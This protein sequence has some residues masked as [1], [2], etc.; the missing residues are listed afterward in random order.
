MNTRTF[1]GKN[2]HIPESS[3][4]SHWL[5]GAM[6]TIALLCLALGGEPALAGPIGPPNPDPIAPGIDIGSSG[7]FSVR[8]DLRKCPSPLCGGVFVQRV[9]HR[10]TRCND[11]TLRPECYVAEVDLTALRLPEEQESSVRERIQNGTVLLN[12]QL[13][14]RPFSALGAPGR[15][16]AAEVWLAATDARPS[17]SFFRVQDTGLVCVAAPCLSFQESKLN[18]FAESAIAGVDLSLVDAEPQQLTEAEEALRS[19]DGILVAGS[20]SVVDGPAGEATALVASQFYL[21]VPAKKF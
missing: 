4:L 7:Y 18:T 6:A 14:S 10:T 20:H 13:T 9:N 16:I 3:G 11:G 19:E 5:R 15:L 17:G 12:G 1:F 2:Q 8:P 21:P